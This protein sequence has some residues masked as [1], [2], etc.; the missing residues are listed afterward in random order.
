MAS[1]DEKK[2]EEEN[3]SLI[4][5]LDRTFE[6]LDL[7]NYEIAKTMLSLEELPFLELKAFPAYLK[8]AYLG[9]RWMLVDN[10]YD[11]LLCIK[12][13]NEKLLMQ[14]LKKYIWVIDGCL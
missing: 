2:N 12:P 1:V 8:Y 14:E 6:Q 7:S 5:N 13:K 11:Y 4:S 9:N 3:V 10:T